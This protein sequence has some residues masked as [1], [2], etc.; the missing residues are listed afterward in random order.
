MEIFPNKRARVRELLRW[1]IVSIKYIDLPRAPKN[2][3]KTDLEKNFKFF[4]IENFEFV[5]YC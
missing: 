2:I 1:I 3:V 5:L 4:W